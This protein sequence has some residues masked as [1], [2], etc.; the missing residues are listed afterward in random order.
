MTVP[1]HA[2]P[3]NIRYRDE[4]CDLAPSC[5]ACPF[6]EC[7]YDVEGRVDSPE[8]LARDAEIRRLYDAGD[9]A[10]VIARRFGVSERTV[11]RVTLGVR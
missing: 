9:G 3:E 1:K 8:K 10:R 6:P 7:R 11:Y 5:L 4:G 2:C